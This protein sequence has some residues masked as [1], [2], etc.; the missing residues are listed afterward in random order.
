MG[1]DFLRGTTEEYTEIVKGCSKNGVN[2]VYLP[3]RMITPKGTNGNSKLATANKGELILNA[4]VNDIVIFL[5]SFD[6]MVVK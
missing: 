3:D 1:T 4:M 2:K 5:K 6:A